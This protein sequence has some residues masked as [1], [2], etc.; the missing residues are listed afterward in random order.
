MKLVIATRGYGSLEMTHTSTNGCVLE[1]RALNYTKFGS[2]LGTENDRSGSWLT[3]AKCA[4]PDS[5]R[6]LLIVCRC[7]ILQRWG[8]PDLL[9]SSAVPTR[10]PEPMNVPQRV[11]LS[12]N[13]LTSGDHCEPMSWPL[14]RHNR[15]NVA[16]RL[17]AQVAAVI[18]VKRFG[19]LI[20][21]TMGFSSAPTASSSPFHN[22]APWRPTFQQCFP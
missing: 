13:S 15:V 20:S 11:P 5:L 19:S 18:G 2:D 4:G 14:L 16:A 6:H 9:V 7:W 1:A 21:C 8:F 17:S 12:D 10:N 22:H 3:E